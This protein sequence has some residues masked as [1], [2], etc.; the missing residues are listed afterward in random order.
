[1]RHGV[2]VSD[3]MAW[4]TLMKMDRDYSSCATIMNC[5]SQ[6]LS[7]KTNHVAK[8]LEY[9]PGQITGTNL[10]LSSPGVILLTTSSTHA[11]TTAR[12]VITPWCVHINVSHTAYPE[13]NQKFLD[14]IGQALSN[15]PTHSAEAKWNTLLDAMH[16]TALKTYD[17]T[18]RKIT[19]WYEA[20]IAV[21]E[22]VTEV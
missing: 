19:D 16:N 10:T 21:L 8:C 2:P 18:E 20:I 12:I 13:K 14:S 7:L 17:K 22:P 6:T 9:I 4:G 11:A 5:P 3:T 15:N 1:M